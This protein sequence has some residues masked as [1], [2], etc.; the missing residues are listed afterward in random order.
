MEKRLKEEKL[1][2]DL[3]NEQLLYY[4]RMNDSTPTPSLNDNNSEEMKIM[5][6]QLK[7]LSA[8]V[9]Y[10]ENIVHTLLDSRE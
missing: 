7:S 1:R 2:M 4:K 6:C 5:K 8:S 10:L 9:A 3:M